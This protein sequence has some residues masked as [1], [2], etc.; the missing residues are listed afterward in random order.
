[1][2]AP[3]PVTFCVCH[4]TSFAELKDA[5]VASLEEIASRFGCGTGCGSCRPYLVRLLETG[6]TE[7]DVIESHYS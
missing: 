2:S 7:F 1:M 4:Q 6:E 5:K 3:K